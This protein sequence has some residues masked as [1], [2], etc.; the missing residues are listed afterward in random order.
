MLTFRALTTRQSDWRNCGLFVCL[1]AYIHSQLSTQFDNSKLPFQVS[2]DFS[3]MSIL[4]F[5][6][7]R[8]KLAADGFV[9]SHSVCNQSYN[10]FE[11]VV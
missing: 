9:S 2:V 11:E 6:F 5:L 1:Y 7:G 4:C 8:V 10:K 3:M